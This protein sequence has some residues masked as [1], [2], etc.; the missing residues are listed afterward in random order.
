[1]LFLLFAAQAIAIS[2][3]CQSAVSGLSPLWNET[4]GHA[5][6]SMNANALQIFGISAGVRLPTVNQDL[7]SSQMVV[8]EV[9]SA[10]LGNA[11]ATSTMNE[12]D[13]IL[14][15]LGTADDGLGSHWTPVERIVHNLHMNDLWVSIKQIYDTVEM[16]S[17]DL[18][19]CLLIESQP[20]GA[21]FKAVEWI[22]HHY[23]SGTPISLLR[24]E[25]NIP[26]LTDAS[27]WAIW[28]EDLLRYYNQKHLLDAALFLRCLN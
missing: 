18:C 17:K 27:S 2:S 3:D 1:M 19:N 23:T 11:F 16:P 7:H 10:P 14:T 20:D 4:I 15:I 12:V 26:A 24:R 25:H 8:E 28:K 9:P 13:R 6:H 21:I 22:A 5:I